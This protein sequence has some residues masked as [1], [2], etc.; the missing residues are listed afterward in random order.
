VGYA[1]VTQSGREPDATLSDLESRLD[2]PSKKYV[3]LGC[4]TRN[5]VDGVTRVRK[6]S[7]QLL[8]K[9]DTF[10]SCAIQGPLHLFDDA[11]TALSAVLSDS[12][13]HQRASVQLLSLREFG[14][15]RFLPPTREGSCIHAS[16]GLGSE[17]WGVWG[18]EPD[19]PS[20]P[21]PTSPDVTL[22]GYFHTEEHGAKLGLLAAL[23]CRLC[24]NS[25]GQAVRVL[26][27]SVA[28]QHVLQGMI[29][30]PGLTVVPFTQSSGLIGEFTSVGG[31][32]GEGEWIVNWRDGEKE[33][34]DAC[35]RV[36]LESL[37]QMPH[38]QFFSLLASSECALVTGDASLN[39]ALQL[40]KIFFYSAEP[41]KVFTA[42]DLRRY[43]EE[44]WGESG[45][46]DSP[47]VRAIINTLWVFLSH[48][49]SGNLARFF[50]SLPVPH[51]E[52]LARLRFAFRLWCKS[53]LVL[54]GTLERNLIKWVEEQRLESQN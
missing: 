5:K 36:R 47:E 31:V 14:M 46:G 53:L 19:T 17:E 27:P 28:L 33:L 41:H 11:A 22:V 52:R 29:S 15:S 34:G 18:G 2:I 39:E 6:G 9:M 24:G 25:L 37:S 12:K 30:F 42:S 43:T 45:E 32:L 1:L 35:A 26:A 8:E 44:G 23:L 16:A 54:R 3:F 13:F 7:P 38:G 50:A 4:F 20:P 21:R 40:G 49:S 10:V 51:E 48:P